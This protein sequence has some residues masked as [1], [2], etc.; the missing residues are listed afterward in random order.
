M[1]EMPIYIDC[2]FH[3]DLET[4]KTPSPQGQ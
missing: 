4:V 3:R 2:V 1:D